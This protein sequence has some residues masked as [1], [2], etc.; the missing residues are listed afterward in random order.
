MLLQF[1][2]DCCTL[3]LC[4]S[5]LKIQ[6]KEALIFYPIPANHTT[7]TCTGATQLQGCLGSRLERV[8]LVPCHIVKITLF[9]FCC[10]RPPYRH[11][12]LLEGLLWS[13]YYNTGDYLIPISFSTA[14]ITII[15]IIINIFSISI[16]Q[17]VSSQAFITR[18]EI[19]WEQKLAWPP[20]SVQGVTMIIMTLMIIMIMMMNWKEG[21]QPE[22]GLM[23]LFFVT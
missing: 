9:M 19:G 1:R 13:L 10:R 18:R 11:F 21:D 14:I 8:S 20:P 3:G 16:L 4:I 22:S 2:S 12:H 6:E 5:D 7:S 17:K 15:T 23:T